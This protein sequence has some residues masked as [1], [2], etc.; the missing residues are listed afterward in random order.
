MLKRKIWKRYRDGKQAIRVPSCE[1]TMTTRPG[2]WRAPTLLVVCMILLGACAAPLPPPG[3]ISPLNGQGLFKKTPSDADIMHEGITFLGSPGKANDYA[4]AKTAFDTLL[5]TY[6]ESKWRNLSETLITLIDTMQSCREKDLLLN[7]AEQE[8]SR[9][10]HDND[11]LKK[12]VWHLNDKLKT[13]T[14]RLSEENE[15]LKKDIQLLK[16]LEVE[17]EKRDKM[18]R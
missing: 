12:E 18:L 6:P 17:L 11:R 13:E 15:Q 5:K 9:L 8:T 7:K 4:R 16:N 14:A 10:L 2:C 3:S 1:I